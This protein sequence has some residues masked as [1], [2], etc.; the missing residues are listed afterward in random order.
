MERVPLRDY[1]EVHHRIDVAL[2][3]FPF[4]GGRT[5]CDALWMGVPV[6]S[7]LGTTGVGRGGASIL[8]NVGMPELLRG[9][10]VPSIAAHLARDATLNR[11]R[12][13]LRERMTIA[14][15][16]EARFARDMVSLPNVAA[17][18]RRR[19]CLVAPSRI[20]V[21]KRQQDG[22]VTR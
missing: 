9:P 12:L 16:D 20:N 3:P 10:E 1:L 8:S 15:A 2:D 7:L 11:L 17:W 19:L 6:V 14:M 4:G 22:G 13:G 21:T 5:T 18:S